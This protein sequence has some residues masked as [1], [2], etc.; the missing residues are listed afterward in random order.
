M[1]EEKKPI[2][3]SKSR[4]K[5]RRQKN[6]AVVETA[7]VVEAKNIE[8]P[9]FEE[10]EIFPEKSKSRTRS[11]SRRI[12]TKK[13]VENGDG[14]AVNVDKQNQPIEI[15]ES[16]LKEV[17]VETNPSEDL[18]IE[19]ETIEKRSRSRKRSK[20]R[21]KKTKKILEDEKEIELNNDEEPAANIEE[22]VQDNRESEDQEIPDE[23]KDDQPEPDNNHEARLKSR[24]KSKSR[25]RKTKKILDDEKSI[26]LTN[27]DQSTANN[28]ANEQIWVE[29][30]DQE[31]KEDKTDPEINQG[32][33]SK[34]RKRSKSRRKSKRIKKTTI[35]DVNEKPI[36]VSETT[37][38]NDVAE[39]IQENGGEEKRRKSRRIKTTNQKTEIEDEKK[40]EPEKKDSSR[41]AKKSRRLKR[42][43]QA[44]DRQIS[45]SKDAPIVP[46][47]VLVMPSHP[48]EKLK[49]VEKAGRSTHLVATHDRKLHKKHLLSDQI[50][51][52]YHKLDNQ[53]VAVI[54]KEAGGICPG[55]IIL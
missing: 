43:E 23:V 15:A 52:A 25:R 22:L 8:V 13:N 2:E 3:R 36:M 37:V 17:T 41:S 46:G 11:R 54:T 51:N 24:K 27:D 34:S 40:D 55:C 47:G 29:L 28:D 30:N 45:D 49:F 14:V 6:A 48:G 26:E 35:D 1:P 10:K 5:T 4:R 9:V 53:D 18:K 42:Q 16:E 33:R 12:K 20:S 21:R 7:D 32:E 39:K 38:N 19:E 50:N 31:V 44:E